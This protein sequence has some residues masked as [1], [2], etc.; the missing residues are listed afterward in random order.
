LQTNKKNYKKLI[1]YKKGEKAKF[2]NKKTAKLIKKSFKR[3]KSKL[4]IENITPVTNRK[5]LF[6]KFTIWWKQLQTVNLI[7]QHKTKPNNNNSVK[8]QGT[9]EIWKCRFQFKIEQREHSKPKVATIA[10]KV[11]NSTTFLWVKTD[12]T[13]LLL[14]R[15][16]LKHFWF[17]K[18]FCGEVA[19]RTYENWPDQ[20]P[21]C[22]EIYTWE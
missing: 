9:I 6:I 2:P 11:V 7:K 22:G 17:L 8:C 21:K 1:S 10:T 20:Q 4:W 19:F 13:T 16:Q 18:V 15:E 12:I 14:F 3:S 5:K